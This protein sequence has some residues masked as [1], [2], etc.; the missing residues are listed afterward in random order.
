MWSVSMAPVE[1]QT[2]EEAVSRGS[3]RNDDGRRGEVEL[4]VMAV[5]FGRAWPWL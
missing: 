3:V 1:A 5:V 4:G 2:E